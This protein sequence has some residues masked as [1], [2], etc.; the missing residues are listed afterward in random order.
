MAVINTFLFSVIMS[1]PG[2]AFWKYVLPLLLAVQPLAAIDV[3]GIVTAGGASMP[4]ATVTASQGDR[5]L[6]TTTDERGAFVFTNVTAGEWSVEVR[7]LGF[8]TLQRTVTIGST[9]ATP[10]SL[11]LSFLPKD[12]LI[13]SLKPTPNAVATASQ[14]PAAK[15]VQGTSRPTGPGAQ[16]R[17][18]STT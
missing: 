12:A 7:T 6:A 13:A 5:Q 15:P 14:T 16:S 10:L 17:W 4:G 11:E 18:R 2:S 9:D 1:K 3:R 8:A